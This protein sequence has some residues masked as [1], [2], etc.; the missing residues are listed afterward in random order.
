[1]DAD[2]KFV[3]ADVEDTIRSFSRG[4][5]LVNEAETKYQRYLS[6]PRMSVIFQG[7]LL[8]AGLCAYTL[9][10]IFISMSATV[11]VPDSARFITVVPPASTMKD[12]YG[13]ELGF[14]PGHSVLYVG[15]FLNNSLAQ[16]K[17]VLPGDVVG[18]A[19]QDDRVIWASGPK[20]EISD[21]QDLIE[22]KCFL[23]QM[24]GSPLCALRKIDADKPLFVNFDMAHVEVSNSKPPYFP[25][26]TTCMKTLLGVVILSLIAALLNKDDLKIIYSPATIRLLFPCSAGWVLGEVF[27][28]L[29]SSNMNPTLYCV[30]TQSRILGTALCMRAVLGTKQ[31][32]LQSLIL[33]SITINIFCYAQVPDYVAAGKF[34]SGFGDPQDVVEGESNS[35][36]E[37]QH[38][39][40][41]MA[42]VYALLRV[43]MAVVAGV[44]GQKALQDPHVKSL[45]LFAMQAAIFVASSLSIVPIS[46]FLLV[47]TKWEHGFFGGVTVEF[48]HCGKEWPRDVCLSTTP[49]ALVEQGWDDRTVF[50]TIFYIFHNVAVNG[51]LKVFDALVRTLVN[52]STTLF[53]YILS[54]MI[55]GLQFNITKCGL[56]FG[57]ILQ[58][59]QYACAPKP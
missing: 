20:G 44:I 51:V 23:E 2:E 56:I 47:V 31:T 28:V 1:M 11:R 5:V 34:W 14:Q 48:R 54:L 57:I 27:E 39:G 37:L 46:M 30:L 32:L 59:A 16:S 35:N 52:A 33:V 13:V 49:V 38:S 15:K 41:N 22:L 18:R 21:P 58:F 8:F 42:V 3:S 43:L 25:C 53:S 9:G 55:F 50:V 10:P 17:G 12:W 7:C 40:V 6:S 24:P 45:G 4:H 26:S 19:W 36:R 29:A